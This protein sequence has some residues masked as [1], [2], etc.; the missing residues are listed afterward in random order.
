MRYQLLH[1]TKYSYTGAISL[2]HHLLRLRPQDLHFQKCLSHEVQLSPAP[3][4]R[5]HHTDYYGNQ[6]ELLSI[7]GT[8]RALTVIARSLV[9][10]TDPPLPDPAA[11]PPWETAKSSGEK[12]PAPD[13]QIPDF[14]FDSPLL[15]TS[16]PFAQYAA[17]SFPKDRPILEA[18]LHF[19]QRLHNDFRFDADATHVATPVEEFFKKRRGVCQD[20]A[21]LTIVCLRSL[22][23]PVRYVSGYLETDPPPG[24]PKLVGADASH[25]WVSLFVPGSGW[26]DLDPTNNCLPRQRHINVAVGR[27]FS[28]V[29]PIKGVIIGHGDHRL[30]VSV[31]VTPH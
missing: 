4:V 25:A 31:D 3:S 7:D 30:T 12:S 18:A 29:S 19:T 17:P 27:D 21:H 5:E 24:K 9:E 6:I 13:W 23:L 22:G 14:Q 26:V 10:R 1:T 15:K 11:T 2:G 8:H 16:K 20:F 28:D